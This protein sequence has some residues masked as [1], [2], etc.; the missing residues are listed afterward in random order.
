MSLARKQGLKRSGTLKRTPL[1]RVSKKRAQQ[2]RKYT[3][4]REEYL[5]HNPVCDACGG[6]ATEIHHKRGRFQERLLDKDFFSPL[7]RGCHQKVHMEPKWAYSVG[8]LI[9]R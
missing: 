1:R 3:K 6:R 9:A 2:N 8:L 4:L 5:K 7:C